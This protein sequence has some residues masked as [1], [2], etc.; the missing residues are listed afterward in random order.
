METAIYTFYC[1]N[2]QLILKCVAGSRVV[3]ATTALRCTAAARSHVQC[4]T[5]PGFDCAS[6]TCGGNG[7]QGE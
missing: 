4:L 2:M 5:K 3:M 1:R 7:C 6:R